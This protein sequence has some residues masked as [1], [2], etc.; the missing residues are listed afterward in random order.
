MAALLKGRL[1]PHMSITLN[2]FSSYRLIYIVKI[3]IE[4]RTNHS[5]KFEF[6]SSSRP[7]IRYFCASFLTRKLRAVRCSK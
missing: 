2:C 4:L 5:K 3:M 1:E 6:V 7:L